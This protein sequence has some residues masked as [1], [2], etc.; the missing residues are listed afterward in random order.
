MQ[1]HAGGD[2]RLSGTEGTQE[3]DV[4]DSFRADERNPESKHRQRYQ[5]NQ[6][7]QEMK[8]F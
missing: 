1:R 8:G 5:P 7:N 2:P 4:F 6:G 3:T